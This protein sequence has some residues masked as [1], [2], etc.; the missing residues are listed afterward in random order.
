MFTPQLG[1]GLVFC[2]ELWQVKKINKLIFLFIDVGYSHAKFVL[3]S[4]K[5][6][7]MTGWDSRIIGGPVYGESHT[8]AS[9]KILDSQNKKSYCKVSVLQRLMSASPV[10]PPCVQTRN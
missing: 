3:F 7:H 10:T 1:K 5:K 4:L 2:N 9:T 6:I 8:H